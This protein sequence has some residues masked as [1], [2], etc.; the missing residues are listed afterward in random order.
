MAISMGIGLGSYPF[1]SPAQFWRW[2]ELCENSALDSLWQ[3]DRLIST[4]AIL[5]P[6]S[7][8]AALAGATERIKFGMNAVVLAY[9]HP[10]MLAKQCATIDYLSNGRLLPCFGIGGGAAPEWQAAD[11]SPRQRGLRANES[12]QIMSLLW[13]QDNVD[14]DGEFYQL[15]G[16]SIAPK[17][18]QQQIPLWVGGSSQAAIVRT[19]RFGTGWI[20]GLQGPD[21]VAATISG[22]KAALQH[23]QRHIADDHY[24]ATLL[25]RFETAGAKAG[26]SKAASMANKDQ[27][28]SIT[29][30]GGAEQ[31][32]ALVERYIDAGASKFVAIPL[33]D[34]DQDM[35]EQTQRL[36]D[37]VLPELAKKTGSAGERHFR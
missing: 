35:I 2:I 6:M 24:G 5:E 18:V 32:L 21:K 34:S 15:K 30:T 22:I 26:A 27:A 29:A 23:E 1:S 3:S 33:A 11:I 28:Q 20:A 7:M 25:Y 37:E 10:V 8:M 16:A 31:I 17:P 4:Q 36:V 14:F 12:L 13:Q 9:R 19:A